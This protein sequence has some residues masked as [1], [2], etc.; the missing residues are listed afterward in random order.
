MK[1]PQELQDLLHQALTDMPAMLDDTGGWESLDIT[2][3][4][5]RVERLF[6]PFAGDCRLYL[7]RLH[8]IPKGQVPLYHPHPWSSIVLIV[9][10]GYD[11]GVGY[12]KG[13]EEPIVASRLYLPPGTIYSM[14]SADGW[15]YVAPKVPTLSI[16]ITGPR[17][18]RWSPGPPPGTRLGPLS[19]EDRANLFEDFRAYFPKPK[20]A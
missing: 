8:P 2:Y 5:P 4:P 1:S 17:W 11:M 18:D 6:R 19:N 13:Q 9:S 15:H 7:H 3:E 20:S 12:G 16:M 10:G 14:T